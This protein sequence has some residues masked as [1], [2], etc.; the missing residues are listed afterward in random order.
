M[1][2]NVLDIIYS[3]Y[4]NYIISMS[5]PFK[6]HPF[7]QNPMCGVIGVKSW[8]I[9]HTFA[10]IFAATAPHPRWRLKP[11]NGL[12]QARADKSRCSEP[13]RC[14]TLAMQA[15]VNAEQIGWNNTNK[16]HSP[17]LCL[18]LFVL[19]RWSVDDEDLGLH[20]RVKGPE[21][22]IW[23]ELIN[24]SIWIFSLI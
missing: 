8:T 11:C 22:K 20:G 3:F 6:G 13:G 16:N 4:F 10:V 5:V 2:P 17:R 12:F 24:S 15:S 14:D 23:S 19:F 18:R 7:C 21:R 9:C 1:I